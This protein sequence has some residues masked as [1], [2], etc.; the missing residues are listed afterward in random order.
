MAAVAAA[1][2][3]QLLETRVARLESDVAHIRSDIAEMKLDVRELRTEFRE[4]HDELHVIDTSL[5]GE[6]AGLG[7]SLR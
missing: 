6:I 1:M 4:M 3:D 5:R 7:T 2:A